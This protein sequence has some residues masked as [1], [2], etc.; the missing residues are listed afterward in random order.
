MTITFSLD[1]ASIDR[2][3]KELEAYRKDFTEKVNTLRQKVG[4]RIRWRAETGFSMAMGDDVIDGPETP[5]DVTVGIAD[6]GNVTVVFTSGKEAVF[7]EFG[8]GVY[9]N[10]AVGSSPHPL[11]AQMGYTIGGYGKGKGQYDIWRTPGGGWSFGTPAEMP[12]YR[13]MQEAIQAF[14]SIVREVFGND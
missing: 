11:G 4:E 2:A 10:G 5:N 8:A 3:I 7:I 14:D 12:M 13:G 6:S 1:S 9:Y